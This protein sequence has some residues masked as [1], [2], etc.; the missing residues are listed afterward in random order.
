MQT[1]PPELS[2][3]VLGRKLNCTQAHA[4]LSQYFGSRQRKNE[5]E[6]MKEEEVWRRVGEIHFP[7]LYL[8]HTIC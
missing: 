8:M 4:F 6:I 2:D 3:I 5:E 7:N 1:L